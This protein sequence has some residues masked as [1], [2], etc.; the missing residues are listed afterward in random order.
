MNLRKCPVCESYTLKVD[1]CGKKA[2]DA[3]YKF[4]KFQNLE[5]F[6]TSKLKNRKL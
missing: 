4:I 6:E 5:D 3:H 1:H 2:S